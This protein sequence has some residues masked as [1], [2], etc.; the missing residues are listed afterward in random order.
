MHIGRIIAAGRGCRPGVP[1]QRWC[2]SPASRRWGV[3]WCTS[4]ASSPRASAEL[5]PRRSAR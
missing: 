1:R 5:R 4:A 2:I 3:A